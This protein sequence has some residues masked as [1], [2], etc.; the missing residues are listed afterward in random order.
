MLRLVRSFAVLLIASL[1]VLS[2]ELPRPPLFQYQTNGAIGYSFEGGV[3]VGPFDQGCIGAPPADPSFT[4]IAGM[5]AANCASG[6]EMSIMRTI[7]YSDG[8][9]RA[10]G[11]SQM[12][13]HMGTV[14]ATVT[15]TGVEQSGCCTGQGQ[16]AAAYYQEGL[17]AAVPA[18][19]RMILTF[20]VSME[21]TNAA[22]TGSNYKIVLKSDLDS[23]VFGGMFL[24]SDPPRTS[25]VVPAPGLLIG[26]SGRYNIY[27]FAVAGLFGNGT[28]SISVGSG[29]HVALGDSFASGAGDKPY[30]PSPGDTNC[31]RSAQGFPERMN[32]PL[33]LV[34]AA[35]GG[36]TTDDLYRTD[37]DQPAQLNALDSTTALVTVMAGGNDS[38]LITI[39]EACIFQNLVAGVGLSPGYVTGL[40]CL[41]QHYQGVLIYALLGRYLTMVSRRLANPETSSPIF[42]RT[43]ALKLQSRAS[44]R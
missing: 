44:S 17:Q 43:S 9:G 38:Y 28:A 18:G 5:P 22:L 6:T 4:S 11:S 36:T 26:P 13:G 42:I 37:H 24:P 41:S 27:V 16:A 35:C 20:V 3:S 10:T 32:L 8:L 34:F 23:V 15:V 21:T 2:Q 40:P 39:A 33:G 30:G 7:N 12:T 1:R 19:Q 29:T 14:T 31:R 25:V